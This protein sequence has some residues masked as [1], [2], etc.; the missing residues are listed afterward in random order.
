MSLTQILLIVNTLILLIVL[1]YQF[2]SNNKGIIERIVDLLAKSDKSLTQ[3]EKS[4]TDEMKESRK[5]SAESQHRIRTEINSSI[6]GFGDSVDKR[7]A[8]LTKQQNINFKDFSEDLSKLTEETVKQ[9]KEL[10][11]KI[12]TRLSE[13]QKSNRQELDKMRN[14][15]DEKLTKTLSK[16]LGEEFKQVSSQLEQ[17][18]KGLGEMQELAKDVGDL[19]KV[20]ANVKT[21]GTWGE[22][23]L[24]RLLEQLLT[25]QQYETNVITKEGSNYRVEFAL[26]IPAKK[27]KEDNILLPIDV[28]F[29]IEDYQRLLEATEEADKKKIEK[30]QK[31][32]RNRIKGQAK[33]IYEKYI[34]PPNTTD[35]GILYV[36]TE[37]LY[38]EITQQIGLCEEL[39]REYHIVVMG[40]NTVAAFLNSLQIGFRTLAIEKRTSKVWNLLTTIKD[41]FGK[42]GNMLSKAKKQLQTVENTIDRAS[43][44]TTTI[45]RELDK[46]E[47]LPGETPKTKPKKLLDSAATTSNEE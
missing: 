45:R 31:A 43:G 47:E 20:I 46:V 40:P 9:T 35:F 19:E 24:Q 33:D 44:K 14:V 23:Q 29:P 2:L 30:Y 17:V 16:R 6:K 3:L 7:M 41:E 4:L 26:K 42:F 13:I 15:V 21:R 36:P 32:I 8:H 27:S 12:E 22:V 5:E 18:Y 28:K 11:E 10:R 38:S 1:I 39:Q 34:D 25:P 37:G